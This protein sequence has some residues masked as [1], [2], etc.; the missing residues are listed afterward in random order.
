MSLPPGLYR[1]I[2]KFRKLSADLARSADD[3]NRATAGLASATNDLVRAN[4]EN[5]A[6]QF[7]RDALH[8]RCAA[9]EATIDASR[10]MRSLRV[11]NVVNIP[12]VAAGEH[13]RSILSLLRPM[14]VV[15][16]AMV[17]KGRAGDGGYV[18]L[19]SGLEN[20]LAY[21]AGI[22]NDVSWD[23]D[24]AALGCELF[25]YDHTIDAL[26]VEHPKFH[27]FRIG[28]GPR[29]Q[30]EF[31]TL[32]DLIARNGHSDRR[33]IILKMD[34]EDAEWAVFES[35]D[36]A[37]LAHF[38]QIVVEMHKL[39][40]VDYEN[41]VQDLER[42]KMVRRVLAKL[43]QTH[44][45]VHVH[46]NNYGPLGIVGGVPLPDVVEVTYVR[47]G[48]HTFSACDKVFPTPLDHPCRQDAPDY[49]LGAL[50]ALPLSA[51]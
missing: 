4:A 21:S 11:P 19:D 45:V 14:D 3:L 46:G 20:A 35:A 33:D 36:G 24:M 43:N 37:T 5:V 22:S 7:E 28:V 25:Q 31:A 8:E 50:G 27:W 12:N 15:G 16:A 26:P 17:R 44:Q 34:I 48:E 10:R 38:A 41:G 40:T 18:M 23:L 2:P 51:D 9:L 47:R 6:L 1:R 32:A 13:A 29:T 30:D 42:F 39:C 49:F